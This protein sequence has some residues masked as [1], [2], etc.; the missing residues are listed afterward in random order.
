VFE[1][2]RNN[3]ID[4]SSFFSATKDTLHQNQYGGTFGG[5]AIKN[6]LFFFAGYQ[7]TQSA[8]SSASTK[9]FVPTAANLLG[10]FSVT[11]GPT[12]TSTKTSVQL[13]NPQ[14]G[15]ALLGNQISPSYFTAQSLALQKYLPATTDPCGQVSFAIPQIVRENQFVTRADWTINTKHSVYGRYMHDGYNTPAFYSPTNVLQTTTAALNDHVEGLTLGETW[16]AKANLVNSFHVTG[17]IRGISRGPAS[18]GISPST[19]GVDMYTGTPIGIQVT[20]SSKWSTYCGTCAPATFNVNTISAADDVNWVLGKHQV[21]FGG[22][23]VR[24]QLNANNIYEENGVFGFSGLYSQGGPSGTGTIGKGQDANLDFLTGSMNTFVQSTTQQ[25]AMRMSV[26]SLY[27]QDVFHATPKLVLSAGVRWNPM[28]FPYDYFGRGSSFSMSNF[29]NNVTSTVFPNAPAG[30]LFYGEAGVPKAFTQNSPLQFSPRVGLTLDPYGNGKTVFRIGSAIVYDTPNL[31]TAQHVNQD[32]PFSEAVQNTSVGGPL[33]F[34]APWSNGQVPTNPF[35]FPPHAGAASIFAPNNQYYAIDS[36][37]RS[38]YTIQWTASVQQQFGRGWQLQL[39]YLGNATRFEPYPIILNPAVYIPGTCG[40]SPCSTNSNTSS[41]FKLTLLNPAQGS[42]YQGGGGAGQTFGSAIIKSGANASYNGLVVSL[43]HRLSSTFVF[44][45]NYTWSHCIDWLD[46]PG[47][48]GTVTGPQDTNNERG[49]KGS[50]GFDYRHVYNT[51]IVATSHFRLSGWQ[52]LA[53]NGWEISPLVKITS[54]A[55]FTVVTGKDNSLTYQNNDRPNLVNPTA[56]YT[57]TKILSGKSSNAQY[58]NS[59][60]FVPNPLGTFGDSGRNAYRGPKFFQ[61][62]AALVR[63]FPVHDRLALQLRFE[64]FNVL[65]HPNFAPPG[66]SGVPGGS[67]S[68][69]SS[70][71]GQITAVAANSTARVFQGAVKIT[72]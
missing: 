57:S 11:D 31:F 25:N 27:I 34:N 37:F 26:P 65:N 23:F 5:P 8:Q 51:S 2:I 38:P 42:K 33:N 41:R 55:P 64:G 56:L 35:P 20:V 39:D 52:A 36:K 14:T 71:F 21:M 61:L 46:D 24:T 4:A 49:D 47:D 28:Y 68:L 60:A 62:D 40:G 17:T 59:A 58:L 1:F 13:V 43:Q 3:Y 70:T 6:K 12:C 15:A 45:A 54:G 50:C 69:A 53:A 16:V 7:R 19:L 18:T 10:D 22:E 32:A 9:A 30:M 72:F 66:S 44:L 29:L 63:T 48:V 67:A